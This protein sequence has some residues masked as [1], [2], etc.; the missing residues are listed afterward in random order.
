[1]HAALPTG[2]GHAVR[3]SIDALAEGAVIFPP[4]VPVG[5]DLAIG[6]AASGVVK[7]I[8]WI[9]AHRAALP[10]GHVV[11]LTVQ[12][13]TLSR[14]ADGDA[15][16]A[17]TEPTVIHSEHVSVIIL[18][19]VEYASRLCFINTFKDI[20]ALSGCPISTR[21]YAGS[22]SHLTNGKTT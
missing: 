7:R 19:T 12:L 21:D 20:T 17:P 6:I 4:P 18:H 11:S 22:R 9:F 15:P 14:E 1:M 5:A 3:F 2:R 8:D 10:F 13:P 16:L